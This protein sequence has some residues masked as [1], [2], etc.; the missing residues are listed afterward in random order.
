MVIQFDESESRTGQNAHERRK[1]SSFFEKLEDC[2]FSAFF[3]MAH[4]ELDESIYSVM[5]RSI[6][7]ICNWQATFRLQWAIVGAF[8]ITL[9]AV[10]LRRTPENFRISHRFCRSSTELS[11]AVFDTAFD[12]Q[13]YRDSSKN[14]SSNELWG[15]L[16][17]VSSGT[18]LLSVMKLW[19]MT[20]PFSDFAKGWKMEQSF[21]W[22][23][24]S[25]NSMQGT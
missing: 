20:I 18:D 9:H 8:E 2:R 1:F 4:C 3:Q 17:L 14:I 25:L 12:V 5:P 11:S 15:L 7:M 10:C 16:R 13:R 22:S 21:Y 24:L 23:H 19:R 6:R